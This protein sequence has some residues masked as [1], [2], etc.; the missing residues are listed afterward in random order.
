MRHRDGF[1]AKYWFFASI[2]DSYGIQVGLSTPVAETL[3]RYAMGIAY[4][5]KKLA[6]IALLCPAG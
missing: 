4:K 5:T 2:A 1:F 3:G 6:H